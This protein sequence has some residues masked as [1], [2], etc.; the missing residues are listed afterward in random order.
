MKIALVSD[1]F[2]PAFGGVQS[3]IIGLACGLLRRGH[4]VIVITHYFNGNGKTFVGKRNVY[5]SPL[6]TVS[7]EPVPGSVRLTVYYLPMGIV[8]QNCIFPCLLPSI[9]YLPY[10]YEAEAVS[11]VHGHS[12]MSALVHDSIWFAKALKIAT[13]LTDH[14]LI[15][16]A[17]APAIVCN[18]LLEG[19]LCDEMTVVICVS[20]CSAANTIIRSNI[21][22][23][24]VYVV[25][26]GISASFDIANFPAPPPTPIR[27]ITCCR[28]EYR[29]GIDLL[30]KI[31]PKICAAHPDVDFV[32][33]GNGPYQIRIEEVIERHYLQS[34]VHLLGMVPHSEMPSVL[35]SSHIFLNTA[36][37][38]AFCIAICEAARMGLSVVSSN[39]GGIPEVLPDSLASLS[40]P[41]VTGL[42]T[43]LEEAI[44]RLRSGTGWSR[45]EIA[46]Q[47]ATKY[48]WSDIC[49]KTEDIYRTALKIRRKNF[50]ERLSC[51]SRVTFCGY[52][53]QFLLVAMTILLFIRQHRKIF[54]KIALSAAFFASIRLAS[55]FRKTL[56]A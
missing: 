20:Y 47:A 36:L 33:A 27:I 5:L 31:I 32:I 37:T 18:K 13:V 52:F 12:S 25:P 53:Y 43:R 22:P 45:S 38:E 28:L 51:F 11:L 23:A 50:W 54:E 55:S 9:A 56:H 4:S 30:I 15:G 29:R 3:H 6:A 48:N 19:T 17:D 35:S 40:P 46:H 42:T 26:N 2:Y 10:I 39:V 16:F 41:T 1:Y 7:E 34:R 24:L 44:V 49:S 21:P 14:S 8:A